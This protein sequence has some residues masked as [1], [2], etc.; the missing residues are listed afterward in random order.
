M[1]CSR[2]S[3]TSRALAASLRASSSLASSTSSRAS[4]IAC[5]AASRWRSKTG[6]A[7]SARTVQP[8]PVTS[9]KP[10]STKMRSVT[11]PFWKIEITPGRTVE[12]RRAWPGSTPK[13]PS[14]PG[15][16]TDS[17]SAENS[18]RSGE[19]SSNLTVSAILHPSNLAKPGCPIPD[20]APVSFRH[21]EPVNL[22][23]RAPP[24]LAMVVA[25]R[26]CPLSHRQNAERHDQHLAGGEHRIA[27]AIKQ[28]ADLGRDPQ[29]L[30]QFPLQAENRIL[31]CFET[32]AGQLPLVA[33]ILQKNHFGADQA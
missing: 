27:P 14:V 7:C 17:T 3:A 13:S 16:T 19:T 11:L 29:L 1:A 6:T 5:R 24:Q 18:K 33:L 32:P 26:Q 31:P 12:M 23:R 25:E 22:G 20:P 8:V 28:I 4:W 30:F 21:F 2:A 10:P 15:T 9:A